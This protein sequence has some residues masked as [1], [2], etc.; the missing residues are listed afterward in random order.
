MRACHLTILGIH[1]LNEGP[2]YL[3]YKLLKVRIERECPLA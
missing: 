1:V 2:S 3:E